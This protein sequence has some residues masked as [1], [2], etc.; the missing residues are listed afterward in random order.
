ME[1][2]E[3]EAAIL[4]VLRRAAPCAVSG[5]ELAEA[6]RV[7]RVAVGKRIG[8]LRERGYVIEAQAGQGYRLLETPDAP[9]PAEVSPL[10][11]SDC[12]RLTGGGTTG[13]TNDDAKALARAG[14]SHGTVILASEQTG[15]RGRL[16]RE[17]ASPAGGVYLSAVLRPRLSPAELGPLPLV[18]GIAV[19]RAVSALGYG[20][21]RLKWPNDVFC[22]DGRKLAG[23][24]IESAAESDLVSWAVIGIG[25][26]VR[27]A[28]ASDAALAACHLEALTGTSAPVRLPAVAAATLDA[29]DAAYREFASAGFDGAL[30]DEYE[31]RAWLTG[32]HVTVRDATGVTRVAGRVA[33]VDETG[34]LV[35]QTAE[36]RTA[37]AAGEVTL[38]RTTG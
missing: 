5:E 4:D 36:G 14:T 2:S 10:L 12:W 27:S 22:T 1:A 13:S 37:V 38:R 24:L 19:T 25:I 21:A 11:A 17:W 8:V 9:L 34:R 31:S 32:E 3:R 20:E 23:I 7:S 29:L 28:A 18:A 15:G 35:V 30:R 33:G 16:G 6:L 26:N